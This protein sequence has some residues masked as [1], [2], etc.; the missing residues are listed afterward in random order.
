MGIDVTIEGLNSSVRDKYEQASRDKIFTI[1]D[2]QLNLQFIK[3]NQYYYINSVDKYNAD[4][5]QEEG[6][7]NKIAFNYMGQIYQNR[8]KILLRN[9]P[10]VRSVPTRKK[11][12]IDKK[13]K[14]T[15]ALISKIKTDNDFKAKYKSFVGKLETQ[16][17]AF[18][19]IIYDNKMGELVKLEMKRLQSEEGAFGEMEQSKMAN[20]IKKMYSGA[21]SIYVGGI[22]EL[23][24]SNVRSNH[25]KDND[26]IVHAKAFH[27]SD[28]KKAYGISVAA[29]G[30]S[31][32]LMQE[33]E[34]SFNTSLYDETRSVNRNLEDYAMV[35][36]YYER[37][38][39]NNP[40]G[41][42]IV[43]AGK[44]ILSIDSLPYQCGPNGEFDYNFV[45][46]QQ[47]PVDGY[48]FGMSIYTDV[49]YIQR[50][51]N[52]LRNMFYEY[53][54]KIQVGQYQYG[55][56]VLEDA[57]A[58]TNEIT[59]LVEINSMYGK[60]ELIPTAEMPAT[61]WN[62]LNQCL[63]EFAA[64]SGL[65]LATIMG[66][67]PANIRSGDQMDKV[68]QGDENSAGLSVENI[69]TA[70][71]ELF[72]KALRIIKQ[73]T[74]VLPIE[75]Y[76]NDGLDKL[77]VTPDNILEDIK[78]IN[79][80]IMGLTENQQTKKILQAFSLGLLNKEGA[81]PFGDKNTQI[82]LD[83][84]G[85]GHLEV[86]SDIKYQEEFANEENNKMVSSL[87]AITINDW[88]DDDAHIKCHERMFMSTEYQRAIKIDTDGQRKHQRNIAH[89]QEHKKRFAK[90]QMRQ[91]LMAA[92]QK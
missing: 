54:K 23:Y 5:L 85:L 84:L 3:G 41:R 56:G 49:R 30:V 38:T 62:D 33:Q 17:F 51:Y 89:T 83:A 64:L 36:E 52:D 37:P 12:E 35:I 28:I 4:F 15:N 80:G 13:S 25:L 27:I 65:S 71:E 44:E 50:R 7:E 55:K 79:K 18:Y 67:P 48:F 19:K 16:G 1:Q 87:E 66:S 8:T 81:N 78:V 91:Q 6:S 9:M 69:V 26:W 90:Q 70:H 45:A 60:I 40:K 75:I 24:V 10:D 63:K 31:R 14:I 53:S 61:V 34:K 43:M 42:K 59:G 73:K 82:G 22:Y 88:D 76:D 57:S 47:V 32:D 46:C 77:I 68:E 2:S 72:K 39:Y 20:V 74:K 58:M 21:I 11:I 86:D 92:S 29:E